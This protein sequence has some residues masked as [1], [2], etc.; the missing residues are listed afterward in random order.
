MAFLV[1]DGTPVP[2]ADGGFERLQDEV[3]GGPK[4]TLSGQRRGEVLWRARSWQA[5]LVCTTHASAEAIRALCDD[6]TPRVCSGDAL[7][8][9]VTCHVSAGG[10]PFTRTAQGWMRRPTIVL[11]EVL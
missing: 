3:G 1:I 11:K 8:G 10:D 6:V 2:V 9:E 4:R 5:Q 7:G